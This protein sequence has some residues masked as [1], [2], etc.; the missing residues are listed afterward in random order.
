MKVSAAFFF[1]LVRSQ[2]IAL[3]CQVPANLPGYLGIW[4]SIS[5]Y[6]LSS[7]YAVSQIFYYLL[8]FVSTFTF[9]FLS[10][11]K[12]NSN[13]FKN[14]KTITVFSQTL[15]LGRDFY[16]PSLEISMDAYKIKELNKCMCVIS[17][18]YFLKIKATKK[19]NVP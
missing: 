18:S 12:K 4:Q 5:K 6:F 11:T 2:H 17:F 13:N 7:M 1:L 19:Y 3:N 14:F 8:N 15:V 9:S 10:Q 16:F